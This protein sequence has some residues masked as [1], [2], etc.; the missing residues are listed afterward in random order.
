MS[1]QTKKKPRLLIF[2]VA[3][4]AE[5]TI[6][7]VLQRIPAHLTDKFDIEV[8]VIDDGSKDNTFELSQKMSSSGTLPFHCVVLFNPVNQGYGGNQ[9]IGYRYAI[10]NNFD[11][12][13]LIH[14]DGQY[15][16]EYLDNL[17]SPFLNDSADAVFGSRMLNSKDALKGGM[18]YY[19][20]YGNKILTKFQNILLKSALSEFHS[21][22]R[23]YSVSSL[24]DIPFE[25]NTNDFHFDT[26]I[27]IQ[28]MLA[29]K[30][31]VELPIPTY[32]G[33][34]IC[35]VN[36]IKYAFDVVKAVLLMRLQK[37]GV[38]YCPNFD[39]E[40]LGNA[41][42]QPKLGY[43]S[44]HEQTINYVMHKSSVLD[45]GA[46]GGYLGQYLAL[47]KECDVTAVDMYP[48]KDMKGLSKSIEHNLNNG[49]PSIKYENFSYIL[50]L[51][52][53]EHLQRPE[54]FLKQ[55][56]VS[57]QANQNIQILASTGN[58][59][60]FIPRIMLLFGQFNYGK[61]GILDITHSRLF[62]F[63]SF[64]NLFTKNGFEIQKIVGIP[65]PFPLVFSNPLLGR[66]LLSLNEILIKINRGL[67][68]YQIFIIAKAVPTVDY[69]L[70]TSITESEARKMG[71]HSIS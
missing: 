4:H 8:L 25:L 10:K 6:E 44:P 18:P 41:H 63:R 15:A 32:Y 60:F 40:N 23:I 39:C 26:E 59:G 35:R 20:Y 47:K 3:Y 16:P 21:G 28:L 67:F 71:H 14:G 33:D 12:V 19:K 58:I 24:K 62:T 43:N 7:K 48:I 22:Y 34:E 64:K 56:R 51:D 38:L 70:S 54:E 30:K 42:Y 52:V 2:I 61:R 5:A 68:S 50:L 69:L 27:I 29:K 45:L 53:L 37:L 49:P 1:V 46:A 36:G 17:L 13:A 9:K 55:L 57:V 31:I 66:L 65:G 11:Y